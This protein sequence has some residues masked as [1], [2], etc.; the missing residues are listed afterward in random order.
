MAGKIKWVNLNECCK[1]CLVGAL[2]KAC[3][4]IET[5]EEK[6]IEEGMGIKR[7]IKIKRGKG[8]GQVT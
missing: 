7:I 4:M 8:N 5:G 3:K 1:V 2:K 6:S